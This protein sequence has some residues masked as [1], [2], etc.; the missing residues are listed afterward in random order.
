MRRQVKDQKQSRVYAT[1]KIAFLRD[2]SI[3]PSD[4]EVSADGQV[5][6]RTL[7]LLP[8]RNNNIPTILGEIPGYQG[9]R[10]YALVFSPIL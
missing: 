9:E 8:E 1:A 3:C 5:R 4:P 7:S 10:W 6:E 2:F